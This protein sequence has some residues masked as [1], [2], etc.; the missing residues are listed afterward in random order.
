[1]M[2]R[3]SHRNPK[4]R[5]FSWD[6]KILAL[7]LYKPSPKAYKILSKICVLPKRTTLNKLMK[8]IFLLP[9]YND[10]IFDNLKKRIARMRHSS[11]KLCTLIFDEMAIAANLSYDKHNDKIKGLCD[12]GTE[13]SKQFADHVLVFMIRGVIKKY[14]QPIAFTFCKDRTSTLRLK[15][16]FKI[17]ILKLQETGLKVISTTCDQGATNLASLNMLMKE[18][19]E[20]YLR[21]QEEYKGGFFEIG[22]QKIYPIYDPPHLIKGIRNNLIIKNLEYNLNGRK[23]VAKWQHLVA[24]YKKEPNYKGARFAPNLTARHVMPQLIPKMKVKFATQ[25]FSRTVSIALGLASGD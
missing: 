24:L 20:V 4:G 25:E 7:S 19:K 8:K 2:V 22:G 10:I 1:M 17:L 9:G 6:E 21:R 14:K 16:F 11:H 13:R 23:R 5:R 3:E 18:T 15:I 12:D